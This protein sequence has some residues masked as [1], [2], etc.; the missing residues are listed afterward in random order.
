MNPL[1]A[2]LQWLPRA[3][4][5]FP[6][7]LRALG[8]SAGPLGREL[9]A[10][11]SHALDLNQLTKLA[12]TIGK[13]RS[14]GKS[15]DPLVPFRLAVVSNSTIDMIVP[16]LVA[17]AAR[18][19]IAVEVIQAEYDQVAQEALSPDSKVNCSKPDAVLLA[20]DYRALP[21][22]LSLGDAKAS[23]ASVQRVTGYLQ[24]L[25]NGIKT[26]SDAVCIFQTF[27]PPVETLFGSLDRAIPG[28]LR[29]LIDCINRDLAEFVLGSG[30]V[31][32]DVAALAETVGLSDWHNLQ[33]W[34]M[35]KFSFSDE[36]IP[37]YADHV[38]RTVAAVRGKSRKALILDLDNTVWGG[39]IGDDGLEG[40]QLAQGDA[41]GEAYLAVQRFALDLRQ[42]GIVLA[43]SSKNSDEVAR[44]PFLKH[45]EMLLKLDHIAVFQAN[46]ND[47]AT[48]IQ[49]IAEELSLGLDSMVFLDDNP[50]ERGLVR[51][52]LPQV[53]VPELPADPAYYARTLAAAG[54]FEAVTF[55]NEDLKRAG[56]YQEN[57]KRANLQKQV[58][59][60]D[61]YLA[62]LDMTITFQPFDATGR[63]RIVQLINKSNQYNLT[64]R[65]Y[66]D[67]EVVKAENDPAVF[68]LQVRLADIFGD[69]GMISIVICRSGEAGLWEIDTWVMSCRVLGRKVEQMVL[70]EIVEHARMAGI[71]K[72]IGAY[73]PTERNQLVVDHYAKLG[74]TKVEEDES[75][76]TRWEFLVEDAQ[77]ESAPM[78][79]VS[80]GFA[81][82]KKIEPA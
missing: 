13:A 2:E 47:K 54:Y 53:A 27:A 20:L 75:G 51:H 79:V 30:D 38:A 80:H 23:S 15:L 29:S 48:N 68:T 22:Q 10:L 40:I 56:Y 12:K 81:S 4:E 78:K 7:R 1:F 72:L 69:N 64:T 11:A 6:E 62:S 19:G 60:V 77:P 57:A 45:P 33:L 16:A 36:L 71:R 41:R 82:T 63:A 74:F 70:R 58:G 24:S 50:V 21:L 52:L 35:A 49:A 28:T 67:P 9:R 44:A 73:R 26:N 39:V 32:L 34:N 18:H 61:A 37:L 31:L 46:W 65:R 3:P 5:E 8:N 59:G 14:G 66:T 25:H 17:S 55:A 42:R 76:S 43:V